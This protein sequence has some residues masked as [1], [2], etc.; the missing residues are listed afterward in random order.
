MLNEKDFHNAQLK[1]ELKGAKTCVWNKKGM[2]YKKK[3]EKLFLSPGFNR[4]LCRTLGKDD[5][6]LL[7]AGIK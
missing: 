2:I 6:F 4:V 7:N 3:Q 1:S 5:F